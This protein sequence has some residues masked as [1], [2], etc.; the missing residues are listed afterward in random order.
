MDI[1]TE[2]SSLFKPKSKTKHKMRYEFMGAKTI[3]LT[4][5][6]AAELHSWKHCQ[7]ERGFKP[8]IE[9]I[10]TR[11]ILE[12]SARAG[13]ICVAKI[14]GRGALF[15]V[16]GKHF[17]YLVKELGGEIG[18]LPAIVSAY[19]V[20]DERELADL[21]CSF[22]LPHH[23]K[24][25]SEVVRVQKHTV[26]EGEFEEYKDSVLQRVIA[27]LCFV[28]Y[29]KY[30]DRY[31]LI[32]RCRALEMNP[33]IAHKIIRIVTSIDGTWRRSGV[34]AAM[35]MILY[36][37]P[38]KGKVFLADMIGVQG[39]IAAQVWKFFNSGA[40]KKQ[41]WDVRRKTSMAR[42]ELDLRIM[43]DAWVSW[44]QKRPADL[45]VSHFDHLYLED[46]MGMRWDPK[47]LAL[48]DEPGG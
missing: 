16:N 46:L 9:G 22:D 44:C 42:K 34:V 21:Y 6:K 3:N 25:Y 32:E 26:C 45:D 14:R 40:C 47:K 33:E 8:K 37:Y 35:Y 48:H 15:V 19:L 17:V 36:T 5:K 10:M 28:K 7:D 29:Q 23:C 30:Q 24:T 31:S 39:K 2:I 1:K 12:G 4:Q 18:S 27:G 11:V 20:N 43:L 13:D 41:V 38:G